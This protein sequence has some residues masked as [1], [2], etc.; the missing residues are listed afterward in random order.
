MKSKIKINELSIVKC[1]KVNFEGPNYGRQ[2]ISMV[3]KPGEIYFFTHSPLYYFTAQQLENRK[4]RE[5]PYY[6]GHPDNISKIWEGIVNKRFFFLRTEKIQDVQDVCK[7][8]DL[9]VFLLDGE[10]VYVDSV[11]LMTSDVFKIENDEDL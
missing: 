2:V 4:N 8:I 9:G 6:P 1:K 11:E 5:A 10:L 7:E 3:F